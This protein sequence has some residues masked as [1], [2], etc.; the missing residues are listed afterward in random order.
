MESHSIILYEVISILGLLSVSSLVY[1]ICKKIQIPFAVGLLISGIAIALSDKLLLQFGDAIQNDLVLRWGQGLQ[2][3]DLSQFIEFSPAIVFF[4]FL[5]TLIFESAYHLNYRTFRGVIPEVLTL[6][7]L[8]LGI[9]I[10]VIGAILHYLLGLDWS[11]ALLFG[12]L[13]SATDP[14]AVLAIFK[15]MRIPKRLST[16]VDGESLLNDGT[17]LIIFQIF[18]AGVLTAQFGDDMSALFFVEQ[19][20]H[21][22]FTII[23]ALIIGACF[24]WLF[25]YLIAHTKNKGVQLT[26]SIILAHVT[27]ICS[28]V[29]FHA[30]GILA[31]MIAGIIVGNFGKRKMQP[32]AQ[33]SFKDIWQFLGFISNS[34]VFLLLGAKLGQVNFDFWPHIL[35]ASVAVIFIARPLSVFF[36]F[37]VIN[38]F[39]AEDRSFGW[40]DQAI[41]MWGGLRGAL[42]AAAVLLIP[43]SFPYAEQ[44]QAMTAGVIFMTFVLNAMTMK[45]LLKWLKFQDYTV[46]EE[47]QFYEAKV[48]INEK[49]IQHLKHI[50]NLHYIPASTHDA[51]AAEYKEKAQEAEQQLEQLKANYKDNIR[52]IEKIL[53][54]Y[55]LGIELRAY[56]KLFHY[57]E[58]SEDRLAVLMSSINR[59]LGRLERDELPDERKSS[60]KIA[61]PIPKQFIFESKKIPVVGRMIDGWY[62]AYRRKK[63]VSR[64]QHY[65]ARRIASSKVIRDLGVLH[66]EHE[67]F[68]DAPVL[69]K[70]IER[71]RKWHENAEKKIKDL[72]KDFPDILDSARMKLVENMCLNR[73]KLIEKEFLDKGFICDKVFADLEA[74]VSQRSKKGKKIYL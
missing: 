43:E 61:P 27:F 41:T 36:S 19:G 69:K 5:P 54:H 72:E 70:I 44:L 32:A 37:G 49:V 58:I 52:E 7:M 3:F 13:I 9:S 28:E 24:G 12:A 20:G 42:A 10:T 66:H 34:L 51:L 25:S 1:L 38:I 16:V 53:T 65:R 47:I 73:E 55:A 6:S 15:E 4:V 48:L 62:E 67:V 57:H 71:Y 29:L 18:L 33:R 60:P 23:M 64:W 30:S 45:P 56:K 2:Q 63:V 8:G 14:V 11:V 39:R 26:L 21:L 35:I 68:A 31:T 46:N 17:A 22:L 40:K 74:N 59:Q 50:K